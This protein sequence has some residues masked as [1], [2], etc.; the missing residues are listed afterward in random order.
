MIKKYISM[1]NY[2]KNLNS[3][4]W[5][6]NYVFILKYYIWQPT[7]VFFTEEPHRQEEPAELKS[8]G[9]QRVAHM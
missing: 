9:S 3:Y 6:I 4:L 2:Y 1:H 5:V 8:M 7:P